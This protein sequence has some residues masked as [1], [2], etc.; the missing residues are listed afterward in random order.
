[1]SEDNQDG[2]LAARMARMK[3]SEAPKRRRGVNPYALSAVTAVAGVGV[4]A[5]FFITTHR[6]AGAQPVLLTRDDD[7]VGAR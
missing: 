2:K 1:M 7:L 6:R 3:P 5:R 4:G